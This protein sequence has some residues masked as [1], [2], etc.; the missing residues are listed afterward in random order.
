ML[1]QKVKKKSEHCAD[2][3]NPI[4]FNVSKSHKQTGPCDIQMARLHLTR[5]LN[6]L[7]K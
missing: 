1:L 3:R 5:L 4:R 7:L 6:P 2:P